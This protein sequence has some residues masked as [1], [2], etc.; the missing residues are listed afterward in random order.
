MNTKSVR[1]PWV[2]ASF[3]VVLLLV[4]SVAPVHAGDPVPG[5]DITIEQIPGGIILTVKTDKNGKYIFN[6]LAPGTYKLRVGPPKPAAK[7]AD[8]NS[9]RS[10][11]ST[12]I[13]A[14]GTKVYT[15]NIELSSK[16]LKGKD[17][18]ITIKIWNKGLG[19]I[20]GQVTTAVE[21][22]KA[23]PSKRLM[24]GRIKGVNGQK[25]NKP[26]EFK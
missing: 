13:N 23:G 7:S 16:I 12:S 8:Y 2:A 3:V 11:T 17:P 18:G 5:L 15:V 25:S 20:S 4:I 22:I 14:D 21:K 9:S 26:L 1:V 10:N 6:R 24:S 19:Q